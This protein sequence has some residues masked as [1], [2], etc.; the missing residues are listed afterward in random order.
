MN[1]WRGNP[2]A[3]LLT[4]S[5]GFF[6]TLL[7]LTIVN[8]AIPNLIDKLGASLDQVLWVVNAY[9][10]ALAVLLITA[11]RLGDIKGPRTL[12]IAGVF[13]F[14]AASLACGL[15]QTPAELITARAA[16]GI[17]AA[18]LIPQTMTLIMATFPAERRGTALGVWGA[19]GGVATIAGP[20]LG[21]MLVNALDWRWIFFVNIPIGALVL[22]MSFVTIPNFRPDR[23]H[24]F[25]IIGVILATAALF[26]VAFALNEGQRYHWNGGIWGLLAGGIV[27]FGLFL[28]HQR[29]KQQAEPL[30]PFALFRDRNF[31]VMTVIAAV[32]SL[33]LIGLMLPM[34]LYLQSGLG[35]TPLRAGLVIA[36]SSVV[37]LFVSP[38]AGR[39]SDKLGGKYLLMFGLLT[40][41]LGL[42]LIGS[43]AHVDSHWYNFLAPMIICGLGVGCLLAPMATEAMRNVSPQ[44][45][46]AASGINNSVR[47]IGSV[48]GAAAIGALM[49]NRLAAG[50]HSEAVK[51]ATE[52]P[53]QA[54]GPFVEG[55]KGAAGGGLSV[56]GQK[57]DAI[58]SIVAHL[59]DSVAQQ[60]SH[61]AEE[62]F[63]HSFISMMH[64]SFTLPI[65]LLVL[66]A[67]GCLAVRSR[68]KEAPAKRPADATA[69]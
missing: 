37:S 3:V 1:K 48:V 5:L 61:I 64:V 18:L 51:R 50:L 54:R 24:R 33:A 14:T 19:V 68:A 31:A 8:I 49:Q 21:G 12:F 32:I 16:Q 4:L 6:M 7:D 42:L 43:V 17:G 41:A 57:D 40:F 55:F 22:I 44:L 20:T 38:V 46:G 34:N 28:V 59:P 66:G 30:V 27:L 36:P 60:A 25:D 52:L 26:C 13:V 56:G 53:A 35:M 62:V 9:A 69:R 63:G 15:T 58:K 10:L 11:G 65:S 2:W 23:A 29:T 47:Q 39:L 45:A 67:L